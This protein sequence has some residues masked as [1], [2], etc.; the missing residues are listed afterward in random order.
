MPTISHKGKG[1][2][3]IWYV[4]SMVMLGW[5]YVSL[6]KKSPADSSHP[7]A[8]SLPLR[9][10]S[11]EGMGYHRNYWMSHT[12][13]SFLLYQTR[14]LMVLIF[15]ATAQQESPTRV[16]DCGLYVK[17]RSR[18]AY[19][20]MKPYHKEDY[21]LQ[22]I[23]LYILTASAISIFR[24]KNWPSLACLWPSTNFVKVTLDTNKT[25]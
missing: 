24:T 17:A 9:I 14:P 20:S 22:R 2:R 23:F 16:K 19:V 7:A 13:K 4:M 12:H 8:N 21:T 18:W 5:S 3:P 15:I 11:T 10:A 1:Q 25:S 6:K